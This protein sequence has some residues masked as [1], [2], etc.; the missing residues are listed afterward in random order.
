MLR[1]I[2]S[3]F[4]LGVLGMPDIGQTYIGSGEVKQSGILHKVGL[5]FNLEQ[6]STP[7]QHQHL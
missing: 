6:P 7:A 5:P 1:E 3:P 4:V 2:N